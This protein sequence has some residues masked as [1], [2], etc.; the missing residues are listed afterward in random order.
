MPRRRKLPA[1]STTLKRLRKRRG[2]N[3]SQLAVRA[4]LSQAYI[5]RMEAGERVNPT[6]GTIRALAAALR[7]SVDKLLE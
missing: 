7:V 1:M 5:A 4:G 3:Q 2:W 6:I